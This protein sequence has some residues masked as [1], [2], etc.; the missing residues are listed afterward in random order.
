MGKIGTG[1]EA[2]AAQP[3]EQQTQK[4]VPQ[5]GSV[6]GKDLHIKS[7]S[8]F[9]PSWGSHGSTPM[10]VPRGQSPWRQANPTG[11]QTPQGQSCQHNLR[12]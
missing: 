8:H 6:L 11:N 7:P 2:W 3:L 1:L 4:A 12:W 5:G 10:A 9:K